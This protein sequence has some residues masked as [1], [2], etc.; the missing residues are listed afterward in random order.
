MVNCW[1]RSSTYDFTD[2]CNSRCRMC[3]REAGDTNLAVSLVKDS[4][5]QF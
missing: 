5:D 2:R 3:Y 1:P 4:T